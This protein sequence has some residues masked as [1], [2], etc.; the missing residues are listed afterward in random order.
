MHR[1]GTS[2]L[3]RIVSL[4]GATL[5]ATLRGPNAANQKGHWES[6]RL[7]AY[8]DSML[9]RLGSAWRD[10]RPLNCTARPAE[11][12]A[13]IR[14]ETC[15]ILASEY[16]AAHFFGVKDPR[17]CRFLPTFAAALEAFGSEVSVLMLLRNPLEVCESLQRRDG[18]GRT[19]AAML[20]LRHT[21]DAESSSRDMRRSL[22]LHSDLLADW[23]SSIERLTAE[24]RM[25]WPVGIDEAALG[26]DAFID[27]GLQHHARTTREVSLDPSLEGWVA[28]AWHALLA[29]RRDSRSREA[30]A[31]LDRIQLAFDT[32]SPF[33]YALRRGVDPAVLDADASSGNPG[34]SEAPP[35]HDTRNPKTFVVILDYCGGRQTDA[36]YEVL[37]SQNPT[38]RIDVL[39]NGSP[40]N[41]SSYI[42]HKNPENHFIG[43]GIQDCIELARQSGA[44]YLFFFTNDA[45]IENLD[46]SYFED[47]MERDPELVQMSMSMTQDSD[48]LNYAWMTN[49]GR[50]E[51]R[52]VH[53]AD[54]IASLLRISFLDTFSFPASKSGWGYDFQIAYEAKRASKKIVVSDKF[55][56]RHFQ[57]VHLI[58]AAEKYKEM[59]EVYNAV[60]GDWTIIYPHPEDRAQHS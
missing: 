43:G 32:A 5:P 25:V 53:H 9:E 16:K 3:S 58:P 27:P 14:R 6:L 59:Q 8:H 21:L 48:K 42:T 41:P 57:D 29:L 40:N 15:A 46:I 20:W 34:S 4:L 11:V 26:I 12:L 60:Y 28:E 38:Y 39:D 54:L 22:L 50:S 7:S 18:M 33:M 56:C 19:D 17:I 35:P 23:R 30:R 1:S 44:E 47:A 45:E 24:L 2:L 36:L 37:S 51:D 31:Q 52:Q 10:W 49:Q 55:L 13:Q